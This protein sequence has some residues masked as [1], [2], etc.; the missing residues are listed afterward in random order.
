MW[1]Y[2]E[3]ERG[4][5]M[6]RWELI[7]RTRLLSILQ[8]VVASLL[9]LLFLLSRCQLHSC[10]KLL[11]YVFGLIL[12]L[13]LEATYAC[14]GQVLPPSITEYSIAAFKFVLN[15]TFRNLTTYE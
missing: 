6:W 3:L 9:I 15:P 14:F 11:F 12:N 7:I 13:T 1:I 8:L 5:T 10:M 4:R 2:S